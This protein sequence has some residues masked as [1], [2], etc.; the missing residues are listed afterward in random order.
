MTIRLDGL[1]TYP[2]ERAD[3]N[4][5]QGSSKPRS[6]S[7]GA[8]CI[9]WEGSW[10]YVEKQPRGNNGRLGF[11][12]Y[13][14]GPE[15]QTRPPMAGDSNGSVA[16]NSGTGIEP[17]PNKEAVEGQTPLQG[18]AEQTL[19]ENRSAA[20]GSV[21]ATAADSLRSTCM[22]ASTAIP[23]SEVGEAPGH[24]EASP[25]LDA[26]SAVDGLKTDAITSDGSSGPVTPDGSMKAESRPV[27]MSQ[28]GPGGDGRLPS[29]TWRGQFAVKG[30]GADFMVSEFFVLEFGSGKASG[31]P[32]TSPNLIPPSSN[33]S[34]A[35]PPSSGAVS[36]REGT[37]AQP[38][39]ASRTADQAVVS[40]NT[41]AEGA[42]ASA[43]AGNDSSCATGLLT[44]SLTSTVT[45]SSTNTSEGEPSEAAAISPVV[46]VSGWGQNRYGEFTLTGGHERATGRLDLNRYYLEKPRPPAG[47]ASQAARAEG[48]GVSH[49][50]KRRSLPAGGPLPPPP[51]PSLAERRTKRTRCPNQRLLDDEAPSNAYSEAP[52]GGLALSRRKSTGDGATAAAAVATTADGGAPG[53]SS[54]GVGMEGGGGNEPTRKGI[55][56][57]KP[58]K[59]RERERD[60]LVEPGRRGRKRSVPLPEAVQSTADVVPLVP[61]AAPPQGAAEVAAAE[62]AERA[63]AGREALRG[64]DLAS[65]I[66]PDAEEDGVL[67]VRRSWRD[68]FR[69]GWICLI[70]HPQLV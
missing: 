19:S 29:G 51:G 47:A 1:I 65:L 10:R 18:V 14:V 24:I 53:W 21:Q 43:Q 33:S 31:S 57:P 56:G 70:Y 63:R 8:S 59:P 64:A 39:G 25:T 15:I 9:A 60:P 46:R 44:A 55:P 23:T 68:V 35:S 26:S 36:P 17:T 54:M 16:S 48:T 4:T 13:F 40:S 42:A 20:V 45:T 3:G 27:Q 61:A 30:R 38:A 34:S 62:L 67:K 6:R 5:S 28:Y 7:K 2:R 49:Q 11:K 50:K 12:Y 32:A 69:R 66:G 58:R 22:T 41:G 52:G 37:E